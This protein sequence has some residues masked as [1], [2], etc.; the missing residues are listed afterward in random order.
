MPNTIRAWLRSRLTTRYGELSKRLERIVGSHHDA[1]DALQETWLRIDG[2][3]EATSVN[4]P[5][6]YLLRMATHI[7][8]NTRRDEKTLLTAGDIN[9]LMHYADEV[10][11]P[12]RVVT[13][14]IELD[15]L[16]TILAQMPPRQRAI[17][18]AARIDGLSNAQIAEHFNVSIHLVN[19]EMR[20]ALAYCRG[21][22]AQTEAVA[23]SQILGRRKY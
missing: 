8:I 13:A 11:D 4:N 3:P 14:R 18:L 23:R 1:A 22:M 16:D 6:A 7:A 17:L 12:L 19:K 5:D 20:L 9:E 2:V 10:N 21:R 15:E